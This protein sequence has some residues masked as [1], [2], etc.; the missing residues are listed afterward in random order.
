MTDGYPSLT[1]NEIRC[2]YVS[3]VDILNLVGLELLLP[4]SRSSN[5]DHEKLD[6][7]NRKNMQFG[8]LARDGF[9]V[10]VVLAVSANLSDTDDHDH[11][12]RRE[13]DN[14]QRFFRTNKTSLISVG[15]KMAS[16]SPPSLLTWVVLSAKV[17][18]SN[19]VMVVNGKP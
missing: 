15:R 16:L 7:T 17:C 5:H 1:S 12:A 10:H 3:T 11:S 14:A 18:K 4:D 8:S 19:T 6:L 9:Y 2:A 13:H